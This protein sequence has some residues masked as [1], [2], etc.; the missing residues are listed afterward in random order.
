MN[1]NFY[2]PENSS[3][4]EG[5]RNNLTDQ[6]NKLEELRNISLNNKGVPTNTNTGDTPQ[7]YYLDCGIKE[8]WD[9]FLKLNYNISEKQIFEDYRLFL[10]AKLEISQDAD[11]EKLEA[12]KQKLKPKKEKVNVPNNTDV[13]VQHANR[14]NKQSME[15]SNNKVQK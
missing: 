7:R 15:Q 2:Q 4:L 8:D 10:Q 1:L 13:N 5:L 14:H 3:Y 11:K 9:E 6:I 12:M